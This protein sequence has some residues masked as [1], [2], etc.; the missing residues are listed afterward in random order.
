[1]P[2]AGARANGERVGRLVGATLIAEGVLVAILRLLSLVYAVASEAYNADRFRT[3]LSNYLPWVLLSILV[4]FVLVWAGSFLRREPTGAWVDVG[5]D[6]RV[7][8]VVAGV[9]NLMVLVVAVSG[10]V[11]GPA[12]VEGVLTWMAIV[13][14]SLVVIA[15][16]VMDVRRS[17]SRA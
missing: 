5:L 14:T 6:A 10:L 7:V 16:L 2:D 12:T 11:R 1:V 8:L 17:R 9:L 13:V 15:G 3:P 4:A